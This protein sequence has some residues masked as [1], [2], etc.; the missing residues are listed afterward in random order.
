M[1]PHL[2]KLADI[3]CR[4]CCG[5]VD[6]ARRIHFRECLKQRQVVLEDPDADVC[7]ACVFIEPAVDPAVHVQER[8]SGDGVP[9]H[10][11]GVAQEAVAFI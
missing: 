9:G 1:R 11:Q 3:L 10:R 5:L 4:P 2:G 7:P 8:S 6:A